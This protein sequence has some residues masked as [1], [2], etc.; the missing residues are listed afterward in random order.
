MTA[1]DRIYFEKQKEELERLLEIEKAYERCIKTV[2]KF[3]SIQRYWVNL[4][5]PKRG[6]Q[7]DR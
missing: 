4:S 1:F 7:N 6:R 2:K 5:K 3:I